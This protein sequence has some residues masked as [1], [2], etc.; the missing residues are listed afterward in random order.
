[1]CFLLYKP[2]GQRIK[3]EWI[4][5]AYQSNGDGFG[6]SYKINNKLYI[7]KGLFSLEGC[8]SWCDSIPLD[9][10]AIVHFRWATHG[11]ICAENCHPFAIGSA[12]CAHNG[13]LMGYGVDDG[14]DSE[15]FM[16]QHNIDKIKDKDIPEIERLLGSGKMVLLRP[17][18]KDL[19]LNESLGT[20]EGGC[21]HSNN[22]S[23]T[24]RN[25]FFYNDHEDSI[26]AIE[27]YDSTVVHLIEAL[28]N[29]M[30]SL[31]N[32]TKDGERLLEK[33]YNQ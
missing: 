2:Q 13:V 3:H 20:W 10:S 26:D 27:P 5:N 1:M 18:H 12:T 17:D 33:L 8:K 24:Q 23:M 25:S 6:I 31:G 4:E 32:L 30:P 11:S 9:A 14:T 16:K 29:A 21:W 15:H 28:E 22:S 19:I 7:S